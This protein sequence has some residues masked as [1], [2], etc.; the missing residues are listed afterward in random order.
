MFKKLYTS[1][2]LNIAPGTNLKSLGLTEYKFKDTTYYLFEGTSRMVGD[3]PLTK[4]EKA[5]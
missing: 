3:L 2:E 1:L 5:S 4:A